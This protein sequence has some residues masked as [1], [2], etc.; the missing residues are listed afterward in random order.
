MIQKLLFF[1]SREREIGLFYWKERDNT[2]D[3]FTVNPVFFIS[4]KLFGI[5]A[6]FFFVLFIFFSICTDYFIKNSLLIEKKMFTL[7]KKKM[8]IFFFAHRSVYNECG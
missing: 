7:K 1:F 5:F 4:G 8:Y 2:F 6:L 3:I